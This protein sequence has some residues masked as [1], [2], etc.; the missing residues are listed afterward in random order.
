[1]ISA[2]L[3]HIG[4]QYNAV[5]NKHLSD[6]CPVVEQ[7]VI[8]CTYWRDLPCMSESLSECERRSAQEG[9]KERGKGWSNRGMLEGRR[10]KIGY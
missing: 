5:L 1:M 2:V 10:K 6:I 8:N 3:S 7:S 9:W 4:M